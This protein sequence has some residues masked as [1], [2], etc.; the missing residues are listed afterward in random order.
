MELLLGKV[1]RQALYW[2]SAQT[3]VDANNNI[4]AEIIPQCFYFAS[5][6][7]CTSAANAFFSTGVDATRCIFN[8]RIRQ[9][10]N[11]PCRGARER[12]MKCVCIHSACG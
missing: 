6:E 2:L 11:S 12:K 1:K 4:P 8:K 3:F 5:A 9:E 7:K 10:K